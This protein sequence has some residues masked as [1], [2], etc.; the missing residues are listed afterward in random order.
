MSAPSRAPATRL[1]APDPAWAYFF[2]LD[3]TLVDFGTGPDDVSIDAELRA[4]IARWYDATGGAVALISGRTI[5]DLDRLFAE[6]H[7]PS[8]GQHGLERR[9]ASGRLTRHDPPAGPLDQARALLAAAAARHPG[10]T[11]EDK[12]ISL[13]LHYRRAVGLA[14]YAHRLL[15]RVQAR[16]GPDYRVLAGK[17]IVELKPAGRDKGAAIREFMQEEPFRGRRPVFLGDDTTDEYGFAVVNDLG[18]I[19]LKVGPGRTIAPWR[20]RDVR[21]VRDWLARRGGGREP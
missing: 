2:D 14:P 9:D 4:L 3:G 21:A 8:A 15:K 17:R 1:P 5:A 7:L 16:L 20:L 10:L 18:G 19:A 6:A 13:A 12:G 11:L